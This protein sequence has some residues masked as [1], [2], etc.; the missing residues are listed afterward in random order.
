MAQ[1]DGVV[2]NGT[3]SAV[4]S[5]IN[6]QY[7]ALW[8][9]H[10]GSTEP[11]SGKVAYQFWADTNTNI[12]KIRNSGN[13]AWI[14]LFTLAGGVD[15]DAASNFNEDVTFVGD[16]SKNAVWDKSDGALEFADNAKCTF[17]AGDLSIYHN[18]LS[19]YLTN[20]TGNLALESDNSVW[21]GSKTN[22]E[23]YIKGTK[24]G[25]AELF[26]NNSKKFETTSSGGTLTGH[27]NATSGII[28][29]RATAYASNDADELIVGDEGVNA[30]QGIT[31]LAHTTKAG[32]I[33]FGDGDNPSGNSRG[34]I[35]YDHADDS[36]AFSVGTTEK[37]NITSSGATCT[38]K[39]VASADGA[40]SNYSSPVAFLAYSSNSND[41]NTAEI[42]QGRFN[43]RALTVS[44]GNTG[45]VTHVVFEQND[46]DVGSITGD[47]SNV[48]FNTSSDYR[49]KENEVL[50][51]DGIER[52]KTL[53]P[54]RFNF[55]TTPSKTVDGFFAHE[56]TAV[57]EAIHGEKD[58]V[59][60]D[61]SIKSQQLDYSKLTPLLTAALQ[62]AITKIE[63][64]E[65]K[66]AV[67]EAK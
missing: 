60:E 44:H 20:S 52:L 59:E 55:K 17:G 63:T 41:A 33:N 9:N 36:L 62:E 61:G 3:G 58:A 12:L 50:I 48:A 47:G 13:S 64:L 43:K 29:R 18:G 16:S 1:A 51:S 14:S 45:S 39:L 46:S 23:T 53:K 35:K 25:A 11:S 65:T 24:D 21:I 56:V 54:Y 7:A 42:F 37:L 66:V 26:Y 30:N 28:I 49:L 38:G 22:T 4:R 67:L 6:T 34:S 8:S 27:L 10:S 57:P 5:D 15:V 32:L 19:S 31:I 2:A 40:G